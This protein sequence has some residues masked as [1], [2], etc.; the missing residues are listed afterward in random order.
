MKNQGTCTRSSSVRLGPPD[1]PNC[2]NTSAQT[3]LPITPTP[4][5]ALKGVKFKR[6]LTF[7]SL[8]L[9]D[10]MRKVR[11]NNELG[12]KKLDLNLIWFESDQI[13]RG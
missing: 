4:S 7:D 1:A 5:A 11:W 10:F 2:A 8:P 3:A 6:R 13:D 9:R 12:C